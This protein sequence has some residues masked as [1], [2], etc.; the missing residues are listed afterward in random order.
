M[1]WKKVGTTDGTTEKF[2]GEDMDKISDLF[3]GSMDIDDVDINSDVVFR[4]GRNG[5]NN[6]DNT[7]AY[8]IRTSAIA[9]AR[10]LTLPLLTENDTFAVLKL[11]QTFSALQQFDGGINMNNT[12]IDKIGTTTIS[13]LTE[14]ASPAS[15]DFFMAST[16]AGM[17]KI[18][19]GNLAGGIAGAQGNPGQDGVDG[20]DGAPGAAGVDGQDGAPGQDGTDGQDGATGA[21]GAMGTQGAT[22]SQGATGATGAMGATGAAGATGAQGAQGIQGAAGTGLIMV[23][24][25]VAVTISASNTLVS[26]SINLTSLSPTPTWFFVNFGALQSEYGRHGAW[27]QIKYSHWLALPVA[28]NST[29]TTANSMVI[30]NYGA[31]GG[32]E[33]FLGRDSSGNLMVG[34]SRGNNIPVLAVYVS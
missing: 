14:K 24:D 22:G 26:S 30:G 19:V 8:I 3:S 21:Q 18:D 13:D 31:Q 34:T 20:Q 33:V 27:V 5:Y 16:T 1:V 25:G 23:S 32:E 6:P 4:D 11:A 29:V 7:F 9:A 17:R 2:G 10:D 15:G 28:A 12:K